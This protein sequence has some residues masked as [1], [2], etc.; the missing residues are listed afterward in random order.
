M[1]NYFWNMF[2]NIQNG[3]IARREFVYQ[4]RKKICEPFLQIMWDQGFIE[5]YNIEKDNPDR[6][7]IG[8]KY[9]NHSP[10]ITSIKILSKPGNKIYLGLSQLWKIKSSDACVIISTHRGLKT[11]TECKKEGLGGELILVIK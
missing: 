8:L 6:L 9:T 10:G 3:Q 7:K 4:K 5:G 2:A 11:L 1:K